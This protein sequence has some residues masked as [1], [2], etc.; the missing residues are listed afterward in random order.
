MNK[1]EPDYKKL[2]ELV[3]QDMAMTTRVIKTANS[4]C[5]GVRNPIESIN[6]ALSILGLENFRHIIMASALREAMKDR[7]IPLKE[8]ATF[9]N[10][11]MWIAMIAQMLVK[12]IDEQ[13]GSPVNQQ[14]AYLAGLFHNCG[15]PIM[16]KK[17]RAIF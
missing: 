14:Q 7:Y 11:S 6:T 10:H 16:A 2:I 8:F 3:R 13:N 12:E 5:F 9:Y 17:Y 15:M 1:A 4:P